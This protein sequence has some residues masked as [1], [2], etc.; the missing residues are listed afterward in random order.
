MVS[1]RR[2]FGLEEAIRLS[3]EVADARTLGALV[4][5][6]IDTGREVR[7]GDGIDA[8]DVVV[9]V[10]LAANDHVLRAVVVRVRLRIARGA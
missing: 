10:V 9:C 5:A 6:Q 3:L 2:H 1:R 8:D 4:H 7:S